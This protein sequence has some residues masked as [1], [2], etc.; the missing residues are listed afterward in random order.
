M[1]DTSSRNI[2]L[3]ALLFAVLFSI[4]ISIPRYITGDFSL[5]ATAVF[6][7]IAFVFNCISQLAYRKLNRS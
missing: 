7:V 3:Y 5:I 4:I 6:F 2:V 1:K